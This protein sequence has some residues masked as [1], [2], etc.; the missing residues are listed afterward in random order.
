MYLC[1]YIDVYIIQKYMVMVGCL[2]K[3]D[4]VMMIVDGNTHVYTH[5]HI[6]TYIYI[7]IYKFR[8]FDWLNVG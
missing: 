8:A 6:H 4:L 2:N 3:K 7:H 1:V 5:A